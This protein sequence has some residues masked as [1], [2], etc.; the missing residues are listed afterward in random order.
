MICAFLCH[1]VTKLSLYKK[2]CIC[3]CNKNCL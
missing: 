1:R 2:N 3:H